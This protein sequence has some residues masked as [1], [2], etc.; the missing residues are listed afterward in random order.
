M[1][2]FSIILPNYNHA[3]F[4]FERIESILQQSYQDFEIIILDDKS[5]DNSREIIERYRSHPKISRII[6]SDSNGG[7]P[8][9]QWKKG[10]ELATADWIWIAETDD[11]ADPSFLAEAANIIQNQPGIS[12]YYT[13]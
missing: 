7:S 6:Y 12:C 11:I 1:P 10:I 3:A 8:F 9:L 5:T 13:D 2:A 4:L